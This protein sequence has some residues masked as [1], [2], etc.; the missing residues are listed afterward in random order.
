MRPV[1]RSP[2]AE[3]TKL[4]AEPADAVVLLAEMLAGGSA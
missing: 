1:P 2:K 3:M 4:N